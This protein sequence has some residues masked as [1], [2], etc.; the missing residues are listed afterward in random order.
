[1]GNKNTK[2]VYDNLT[3]LDKCACCEYYIVN[4]DKFGLPCGHYLHYPECSNK[5]FCH[6]EG[7]V[8]C[9]V[10]FSQIDYIKVSCDSGKRNCGSYH[11][12]F[13]KPVP[14]APPSYTKLLQAIESPT[15]AQITN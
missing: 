3:D 5:S 14:Q 7:I 1:M 11:I 15:Y 12:Q 6:N 8:D 2:S 9:K 4:T 10:C 13:R